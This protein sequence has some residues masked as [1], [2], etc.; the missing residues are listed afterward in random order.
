MQAHKRKEERDRGRDYPEK[1]ILKSHFQ[2]KQDS[3]IKL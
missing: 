3:I 2:H 1:D